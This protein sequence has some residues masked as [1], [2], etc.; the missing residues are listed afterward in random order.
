MTSGSGESL[1]AALGDAYRVEREL[2]GGGMSRVFLATETALGRTVVL[3]VLPPDL[4]AGLSTER[5]RREI[6]LAA[7]LQH[8]H[9]VPLFSAG[10][11]GDFVY[12]TMP[13][14]EGESLRTRLARV[15]EL[16]VPLA[17]KIVAQVAR[18]LAYAHRHGIVHR[19]IKPGNILLADDEAQVADFGIAKALT[20]S[21]E[22]AGTLTSVGFAVG[23][24]TYM[25]PEQAVGDPHV[26]HRADL[27][28]L[29][30]VA[31]EMLAGQAPFVGRTAQQLLVAHA[32]EVPPPLAARRPAAPPA[33]AE[34]VMRLLAKRPADRPQSAEDVAREAEAALTPAAGT[35]TVRVAVP[36]AAGPV[37]SGSRRVL[38][39]AAGA[40]AAITVVFTVAALVNRQRPV[41]VEARVVAVAPFR[42]SA[43]DSSLAYLREGIVDLL[44][45]K[46]SGTTTL[47]AADPRTFLNSWRRAA[48]GGDLPEASALALAAGLGAGR[49]VE[50]EV[51]GSRASLTINAALLDAPGGSVR[52]RA[53][54]EGPADSVARLVD[55]LAAKVLALGAGE[56]EQRLGAL[57]STSLPALRAYLDG[58]ALVRGGNFEGGVKKFEEAL[59]LDSTFA[60]AGLGHIR[61]GEWLGRGYWGRGA[62]V[63]WRHR[64]RLSPRDR[65]HLESYLGPRFPERTTFRDAIAAAERFVNL[66]GDSPEAWYRLA[67]LLYHTG[68]AAGYADALP[69]SRQAFARALALDST[70]APAL[71]HA[72]VLAVELGD[73]AGARKG[74]ALQLRLDST[75]A[76]AA[77]N[78]LYVAAALGDTA[79]ES[80]LAALD[81]MPEGAGTLLSHAVSQGIGS[82]HLNDLLARGRS[83]AVTQESREKRATAAYLAHLAQGQPTRA[84]ALL[85]HLPEESRPAAALLHAVTADGDSAA[86][87]RAATALERA[88]DSPMRPTEFWSMPGR[89]ALAQWALDHGKPELARRIAAQF[90]A[91][92]V[93]PDSGWFADSPVVFALA[94]EAQ[95]A[96]RTDTAR[97]GVL[98]KQLDSALVNASWSPSG[99]L[100]NRIAARLHEERAELPAALAALR[101]RVFDLFWAP[102]YVQFH[103]DEARLAALTGDREG[104][105]RAYRRYLGLRARAEP[106]LQPEYQRVKADLE[107]LER[108]STDRP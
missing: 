82:R 70:F 34:L 80:R 4:A 49:L 41:K 9:I 43:A 16:P 87:A 38:W 14:V 25:A 55:Q 29:G 22:A 45:A 26:D 51:V 90:R 52:A 72:A 64:D 107:A 10:Q 40:V 60:L 5:F 17:T 18:A 95:L 97:A 15:G 36:E 47:R 44:A 27:Y 86:G 104:A 24:P 48:G 58:Q 102:Q 88:L 74:L 63:A 68:P 106:R 101:R 31:Y 37:A 75:S 8:L 59:D 66:G 89:Y 61:A 79:E 20:A 50:G 108:E 54:V 6:Q 84:A 35:A 39:M 85:E 56:G 12:Y 62:D 73:T 69:R 32:T 1:Q 96:Q 2:G 53:S 23:T 3:K 98:L 11:A 92:Q 105:I 91:T 71:E 30:V 42:V 83:R 77:S 93:P 78:R 19:D 76:T 99:P 57:T 28:S 21:A 100:G 103:H 33:L 7:S 67:D 81:S 46:L 94:L 65:A 13:F